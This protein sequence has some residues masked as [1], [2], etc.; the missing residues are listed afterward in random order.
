M[1]RHHLP[2]IDGLRAVAVLSV[3]FFHLHPGWLSGGFA[4]VDVFF[5]ISGYVVAA[6]LWRNPERRFGAA[7]RGF[8]ARRLVRLY[9]ALVLCLLATFLAAAIFIPSSWLSSSIWQTGLLAY[10]GLGNVA[11]VML[12][13][14]YFSPRAEFNPFTHMWSLGVEEQFYLLFPLLALLIAG[15]TAA[16]SGLLRRALL[17]CLVASGVVSLG[18]A[19]W[20]TVEQPSAA[21]YLLPA[22]WWE[23][24]A[25]VGLAFMHHRGRWILGPRWR[26]QFAVSIGLGLVALGLVFSRPDA[27]PW[28]WALLAVAGTTVCIGGLVAEGGD[29]HPI[30]KVLVLA[31]VLYIGRLSY[32]LYL[33]HWPVFVLFRWTVGLDTL[34]LQACALLCSVAAASF[35][36]HVVEKPALLAWQRGSIPPGRTLLLGWAGVFLVAGASLAIVMARPWLNQTRAMKEAADWYPQTAV[37]AFAGSPNAPTLWVLGDSHARAMFT[38]LSE[39]Q[40]QEGLRV[41]LIWDAGCAIA[42]PWP[43]MPAHCNAFLARA[44]ARVL[45]GAQRGD[46]LLLPGLRHIAVGRP[47]GRH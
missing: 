17:I 9:P 22:R 21:Y 43:L 3:V 18:Y 27:F 46:L 13:D 29:R 5:V 10:L 7:L 28:P 47:V 14:A 39:V 4:G 34:P 37:S 11:Q 19:A 26:A 45:A 30:A 8:F 41:K 40:A 15:G 2:A 25:G 1:Q 24:S 33:W 38:T 6:S 12:T 23:L 42:K 35:C 20:A 31:P 32:S 44:K 16:G 36:H